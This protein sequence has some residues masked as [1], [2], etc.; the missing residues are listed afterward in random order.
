MEKIDTEI[1]KLIDKIN[2]TSHHVG[3]EV[4][5]PA[6]FG[7]VVDDPEKAKLRVCVN[8]DLL[9]KYIWSA[10]EE[11][12]RQL[13]EALR[14]LASIMEKRIIANLSETLGAG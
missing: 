14:R 11:S 7:V 2:T 4:K 9:D 8:M 6:L 3:V 13:A 10:P 12:Q 5:E 1:F